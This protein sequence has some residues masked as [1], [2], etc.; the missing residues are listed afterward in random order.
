VRDVIGLPP[1]KPA[2]DSIREQGE[3]AMLGNMVR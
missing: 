3:H 1:E 2:Q